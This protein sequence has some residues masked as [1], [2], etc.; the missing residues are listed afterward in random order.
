[1]GRRASGRG[2]G[3]LA[4]HR[5]S[6][7]A[8]PPSARFLVR[9]R[10]TFSPITDRWRCAVRVGGVWSWAV[11]IAPGFYLSLRSDPSK[12]G[13]RDPVSVLVRGRPKTPRTIDF[14]W[15]QSPRFWPS[16]RPWI[17]ARCGH[18]PDAGRAPPLDPRSD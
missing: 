11:L 1:V 15:E 8:T 3:P 9:P 4:R 14:G 13:R 10:T 2:G 18:P 7:L 6:E 5:R 16:W 17:D 12:F